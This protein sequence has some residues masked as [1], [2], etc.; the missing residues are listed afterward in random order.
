MSDKPGK[1][2]QF[3]SELKRRKVIRRNMVYAATGFAILELVSII[4]EPFGLPD[5]TLKLVFVLL[6]IGFVISI[7]LSWYYDFTSEGLEKIKSAKETK[8]VP[9]EKPSRLIAWKIATYTSVII[10]V[11]LVLFQ[12]LGKVEKTEDIVTLDKSI[13]VLPFNSL[14]DDPEK[15]YLADGV[16]DAILLCGTIPGNR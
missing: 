14:S 15:Q 12:I 13:A 16:M 6:C 9:L 1:L 5:W 7:I 10:I 2:A 8:E 3:W 11:G 4:A